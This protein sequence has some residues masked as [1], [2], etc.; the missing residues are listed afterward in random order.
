V[1]LVETATTVASTA[2]TG[3]RSS[4]TE[5]ELPTSP[6][7]APTPSAPVPAAAP[8]TRWVWPCG[9]VGALQCGRLAHPQCVF[10]KWIIYGHLPAC[11]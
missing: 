3:L 9:S 8:A 2:G 11:S 4:W 1:E 10:I 7:R 6:P 5:V